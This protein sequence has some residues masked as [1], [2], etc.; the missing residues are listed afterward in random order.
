MVTVGGV[1][2]LAGDSEEKEEWAGVWQAWRVH[3]DE[4][5]WSDGKI[6]VMPDHDDGKR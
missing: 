3:G 6:V 5:G 4:K 1:V 2:G